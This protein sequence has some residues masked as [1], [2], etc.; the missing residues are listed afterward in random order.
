MTDHPIR[1][2]ALHVFAGIGDAESIFIARFHP[3]DTYPIFWRG[4]SEAAVRQQAEAFRADVI[5]KHEAK[6]Q[7]RAALRART[8]ARQKSKVE[9]P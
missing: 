3:Y 7:A 6:F 2:A 1:K 4:F 9:A 5:E 8:K